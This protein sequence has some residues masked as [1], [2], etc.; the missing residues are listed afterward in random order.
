MKFIIS[1]LLMFNFVYAENIEEM[2][3]KAL[4]AFEK[5]EYKKSSDILFNIIQKNDYG[6]AFTL[7]GY[8]LE[9]GLGVPQDCKTAASLYLTAAANIQY[10]EAYQNIIEMIETGH[11]MKKPD[12]KTADKFRKSMEGCFEK[13]DRMY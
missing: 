13:K 7:F 5:K 9:Y 12:K 1:L 4:K 3:Q 2:Y 6:P 8:H 11:C 10:C